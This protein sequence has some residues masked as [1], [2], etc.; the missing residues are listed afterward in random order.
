MSTVEVEQL[1]KRFGNFYAVRDI[2]F[3]VSAGE[4]FGFLGPNGAGK[5]TTMRM[6]TGILRPTS[7]T[8]RVAGFDV[9]RDP[10]AVRSRIGY[11]SQRF[12]LYLDLT[13]RENLDFFSGIYI[14]DRELLRQR[15]AWVLE[16]T[17]LTTE[18]D[19]LTEALPAGWRQRLA[20]A[21]AIVHQPPIL[22]LDEPTAGVD[23]ASRRSFWQLIYRLAK[24][25]STV[26]VSTHYMD[27]AE[28]CDRLAFIYAGKIVALGS[29]ADIKRQHT[30]ATLLEVRVSKPAA[31]LSVVRGLP[32]VDDASL[33]GS[34]LH[35]MGQ[36]SEA[37]L[38]T[39][40]QT[41]LAATGIA[42]QSIEA[43]PPSL[44]D[45]FLSLM[46]LYPEV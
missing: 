8:A 16:Q 12:S 26:F 31:A 39:R 27:E 42:V 34:A 24:A 11:M 45:V 44:E 23:P 33:H 17:E 29:P 19:T 3:S 35:V 32:Q 7:G 1:T 28:H 5:S 6:L 10:H 15:K 21:C 18:L 30:T 2:S 38:K 36:V 37:Q 4:V 46:R 43:I 22:F 9:A 14:A 40:V 13:V 20:L 25:G 41:G